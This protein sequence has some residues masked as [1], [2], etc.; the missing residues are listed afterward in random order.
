MPTVR[1]FNGFVRNPFNV[2][3]QTSDQMK[4]WL[5]KLREAAPTMVTFEL[6]NLENTWAYN[7]VV[8]P[9]ERL[10]GHEVLSADHPNEPADRYKTPRDAVRSQCLLHQRFAWLQDAVRF[11]PST[12]IWVWLEPTIF[13]QRGVTRDHVEQFLRNVEAFPLDAISLPGMWPKVQIV[14]HIAHW[15][16]AGSCWVCP[17]KYALPVWR[18]VRPLVELRTLETNRLCWD[19]TT[20][21]YVELLNVLPMRWYPGNHDETQLTGYLHGVNTWPTL[22][23]D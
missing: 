8:L 3:H 23:T 4:E 21:A 11:D 22:S 12:D 15:R 10:T 9:V 5:E 16:F 17:K 20:W 1:V 19:M 18:V 6:D 13:K 7:D 14:D 2:I